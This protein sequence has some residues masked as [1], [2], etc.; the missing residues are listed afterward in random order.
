MAEWRGSTM[1]IVFQ[2]FQLIPNL[3]V[4][5]NI[6]LPMNLL[7]K[8]HKDESESEAFL[9]LN[10]VGM[11]KHSNKMPFELSCGEQQRVAIA[12]GLANNV[13]ILVADEPTGNLDSDN[14]AVILRLF[15]TLACEGKTIIMV[16]HEREYIEGSTRRIVLKDGV[17]VQDVN[18]V[19]GDV[20]KVAQKWG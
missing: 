6:L 7:K 17:I 11:E 5:E 20:Q 1:G 9:L 2:F 4:L 14:A 10:R 3:S 8:R 13:P 19:L 12:R 16:T 18:T 15:N